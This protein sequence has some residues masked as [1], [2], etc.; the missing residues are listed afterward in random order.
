VTSSFFCFGPLQ[1]VDH[2][3]T[4]VSLDFSFLEERLAF[5]SPLFR[6]AIPQHIHALY[7]PL[8]CSLA[9][10]LAAPIFACCPL[11]RG[12]SFSQAQLLR[13]VEELLLKQR[14]HVIK[15]AEELMVQHVREIAKEVVEQHF[16]KGEG[17]QASVQGP[18]Q[19]R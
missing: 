9:I 14:E 4:N 7:L 13:S 2:P 3:Y 10:S 6:C 15:K 1:S 18:A 5:H 16:A 8:A 17:T 11:T 19:P 12:P